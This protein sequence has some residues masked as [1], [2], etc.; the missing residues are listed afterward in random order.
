MVLVRS[1]KPKTILLQT[2]WRKCSA[3]L[4]RQ[5]ERVSHRWEQL[6]WHQLA[7]E[8]ASQES[9]ARRHA[10]T[11]VSHAWRI[12]P[13]DRTEERIAARTVSREVRLTFLQHELRSRRFLLLPQIEFWETECLRWYEWCSKHDQHDQDPQDNLDRPPCR[14]SHLPPD[15]PCSEASQNVPCKVNCPG[16]RGDAEI[17]DMWRR[18]RQNAR[19]WKQP[20]AVQSPAK[21]TKR[22]VDLSSMDMEALMSQLGADVD[23]DF[24]DAPKHDMIAFGV[25][26]STLPGGEPPADGSSHVH[27]ADPF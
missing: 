21:R 5:L 15:H 12:N 10:A 13:V 16:R 20:V 7:R 8:V 3:R 18:C 22:R 24:G 27:V 9:P 6:E 11:G 25:D 26:D 19:S 23:Q 17:L 1:V 2:W 14:P 4:R